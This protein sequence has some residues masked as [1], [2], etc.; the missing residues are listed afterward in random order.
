M[1][2]LYFQCTWCHEFYGRCPKR[3]VFLRQPEQ[4]QNHLKLATCEKP[5]PTGE[6][7]R[8]RNISVA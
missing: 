3:K 4:Q 1:W 8:E 7:E 6:N 5:K 2:P